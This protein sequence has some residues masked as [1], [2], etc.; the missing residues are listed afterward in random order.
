MEFNQNQKYYLTNQKMMFDFLIFF[1]H[2][3]F[4]TYFIDWCITQKAIHITRYRLKKIFQNRWTE[5][6]GGGG[7]VIKALY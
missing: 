7:R 2:L 4:S 1:F 3:F 5:I 6:G